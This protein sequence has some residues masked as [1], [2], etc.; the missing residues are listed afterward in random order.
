M[1]GNSA[2]FSF[3][4]PWEEEKPHR[5]SLISQ[6]AVAEAV[7]GWMITKFVLSTLSVPPFSRLSQL[8]SSQ[9]AE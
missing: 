6:D 1:D 3:C 7:G 5:V 8:I 2:A 4:F 9:S